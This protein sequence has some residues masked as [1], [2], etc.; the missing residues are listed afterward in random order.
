LIVEAG[1]SAVPASRS[2]NSAP[3]ARSRTETVTLPTSAASLTRSAMAALTCSA[4]IGAPAP[5]AGST[6]GGGGGGG[7]GGWTTGPPSAA[8][9]R[10]STRASIRPASTTI[11]SPATTSLPGRR[12][13][14][15]PI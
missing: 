5:A 10:T 1:I 9:G 3:V 14:V 7:T 8:Q 4:V 11:T 13:A 15:F 6:A 12:A 2:Y